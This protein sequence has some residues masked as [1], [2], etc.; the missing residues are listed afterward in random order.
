MNTE[1]SK[2]VI[3]INGVTYEIERVFAGTKTATELVA[4]RI[5]DTASNEKRLDTE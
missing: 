2:N 5:L 1:E 4:D 3:Q